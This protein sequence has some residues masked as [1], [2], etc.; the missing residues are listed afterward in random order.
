MTESDKARIW[1]A[2][3]LRAQRKFNLG[4]WLN[5]LLPL[6]VGAALIGA[7][8]LIALRTN[9]V[10]MDGWLLAAIAGGVV[11]LLAVVSWLCARGRFIGEDKALVRLESHMNL[12]NA[13]TAAA[14]G[15]AAWPAPPQSNLP[16][17]VTGGLH[18]RWSAVLVPVFASLAV[19]AAGLFIPVK[20]I[21]KKDDLPPAEPLAWEQMENWLNTIEEQ[22][23][24]EPEAIEAYREDVRELRNQPQE[25]WFS[26]SSMEASDSLRESLGRDV[27]KLGAEMS[28][29]ERDL[30]VVEK[31]WRSDQRAEAWRDYRG[32]PERGAGAGN[33]QTAP[34]QGHDGNAQ[35]A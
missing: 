19:L 11:L 1:G 17:A 14:A 15:V 28:D 24:V 4:W 22:D 30:N 6:L 29:A 23:V 26:H 13:L 7:V 31:F 5:W 27:Q 8:V 32:L 2:L 3:A 10:P 20:G 9:R 16:A 34:E 12:R 25:D 33:R 35:G 21:A 18:W